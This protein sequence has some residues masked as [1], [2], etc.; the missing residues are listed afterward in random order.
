MT[1][2]R[3]LRLDW[4]A[5]VIP[6]PG[7][8]VVNWASKVASRFHLAQGA[9]LDAGV[10]LASWTRRWRRQGKRVVL[11][12][13]S[14]GGRVVL[15]AAR[16]EPDCEVVALCAAHPVDRLDG[17]EE[18][19]ALVNVW[20]RSDLALRI[21]YPV[22]SRSRA[23]GAVGLAVAGALN[24]D[25][26]DR[27]GANH[28]DTAKAV[29]EI[30]RIGLFSLHAHW[31]ESFGLPRVTGGHGTPREAADLWD[32][33]DLFSQD[34]LVRRWLYLAG[35]GSEEAAA[36]GARLSAWSGA[37]R[38]ALE[39]IRAAYFKARSDLDDRLCLEL[40]GQLRLWMIRDGVAPSA[41]P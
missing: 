1:G 14:L 27:A 35:S 13:F 17:L 26:S 16:I 10:F 36:F 30:A 32:L 34:L 19:R 11:V 25:V 18:V 2:A 21:V 28:L 7:A 29:E 22:V 5:Q 6:R 12:G 38:A 9:A 37:N 24:V 8:K 3:V 33:G 31:V 40:I 39:G 15:E 41:A 4:S 23:C 20:S